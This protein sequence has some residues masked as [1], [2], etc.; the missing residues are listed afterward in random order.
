MYPYFIQIILFQGLFY[1]AYEAFLKK[2]TFFTGN[3]FYL[4]VSQILVLLLPLISIPTLQN[5]IPTQYREVYSKV[6]FNV[7]KV[8]QLNETITQTSSFQWQWL[9]LI[10]SLICLILFIFKLIQLY[11]LYKKGVIEKQNGYTIVT[12]NNANAAFSF[13]NYIFIS[14]KISEIEKKQIITHEFIHIQQKHSYDLLFFEFLRIL[15]WF[16]PMVYLYQKRITEIHEYLVD[17][18]I[19]AQ[20]DKKEYAETIVNAVF[21]TQ[22]ISLTNQYFNTSLLKKRIQMIY[23]KK[24]KKI[25]Q[26]KYFSAIPICFISLLYVACTKTNL[27]DERIPESLNVI[28]WKAT[29]YKTGDIPKYLEV[30]PKYDYNL[31]NFLNINNSNTTTDAVVKLIKIHPNYEETTTRIAFL[32]ANQTYKMKNIPAGKYYLKIAYGNEWKEYSNSDL[33]LGRFQINPQYEKGE[34]I[35]DFTPIKLSSGI[36]VPSYELTLSVPSKSTEK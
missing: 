33:S 6:L 9:F 32:E 13:W 23:K 24:S 27:I 36:D 8:N 29:N 12:I 3:R 1:I 20:T 16:N 18:T 14:S 15:F 4:L 25:K 5:Q 19:T 26:Y 31:D 2:E 34:D 10:G 7:K 11:K 21:Q 22:N 35:I 30:D 17:N 28:P